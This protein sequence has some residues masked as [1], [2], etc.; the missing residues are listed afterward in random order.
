[1]KAQ[2][3]DIDH[4]F[5]SLCD[6]KVNA[7]VVNKDPGIHKVCLS[8]NLAASQTRQK[9]VRLD[10]ARAGLRETNSIAHPERKL[11]TNEIR[12]IE[13]RIE[14]RSPV[15]CWIAVTL[16]PEERSLETKIVTIDRSF[17]R[18]HVGSDLHSATRDLVSL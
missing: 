17:E 16:R 11:T 8:L 2:V 1:M 10:Q 9:T 13:D 15:V 7:A 4:G 5:D 14:P 18:G 3:V 6:F 12:L